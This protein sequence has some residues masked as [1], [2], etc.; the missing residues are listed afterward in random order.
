LFDDRDHDTSDE[1]DERALAAATER[2]I[3]KKIVIDYHS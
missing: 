2:E 3:L 1:E